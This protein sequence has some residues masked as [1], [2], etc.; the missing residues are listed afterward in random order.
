[1]TID[2]MTIDIVLTNKQAFVWD[3]KISLFGVY[4][5]VNDFDILIG[6][7][8]ARKNCRQSA[9]LCTGGGAYMTSG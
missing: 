3:F 8:L 9:L 4:W 7:F 5:C 2:F 6:D 1:M